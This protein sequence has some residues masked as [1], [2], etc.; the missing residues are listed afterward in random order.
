LVAV[1]IHQHDAGSSDVSFDFSLTG[2]PGSTAPRINQARFSDEL[3]AYWS[4]PAAV[5][6]EAS[7][8][9]GPWGQISAGA[10]AFSVVP[11]SGQKFYRLR[12]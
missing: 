2:I 6:E 9:T 1:E 4:D 10:T 3:V 12:K 7:Q 11:E 8:I 5:L